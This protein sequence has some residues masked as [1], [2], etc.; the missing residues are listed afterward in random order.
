MCIRIFHL[1]RLVDV[2]GVSGCGLVAEGCVFDTG[3]TVVHWLGDH[4]S[5]NIYHS[6]SDVEF[7]HGHNG[8]TKL[9]WDD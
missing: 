2:S 5:V 3:E 6:L 4:G 1:E 9:V 7:V 8:S